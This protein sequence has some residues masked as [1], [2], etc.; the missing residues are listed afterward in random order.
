MQARLQV[1]R[2]PRL[3]AIVLFALTAAVVL[4]GALGYTIRASVAGP[5]PSHAI[6]QQDSNSPSNLNSN[7]SAWAQSHKPF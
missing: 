6:V 3:F 7:S 4:G 2:F 5:G 1:N